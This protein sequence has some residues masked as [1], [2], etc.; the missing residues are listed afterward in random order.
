MNWRLIF[1][2]WAQVICSNF[3]F[4]A[5]I[6]FFS[7]KKKKKG[8]SPLNFDAALYYWLIKKKKKIA[9][10]RMAY[11]I[12]TRPRFW[13]YKA[14]RFQWRSLKS[15]RRCAR[16]LGRSFEYLKQRFCKGGMNFF[17]YEMG[18]RGSHGGKLL[19]LGC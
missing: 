19:W 6:N 18:F 9:F 4:F 17:A 10:L 2:L 7:K 3:W 12:W 11:E 8:Y 1:I 5:N 15:C 14:R 13:A 16:E